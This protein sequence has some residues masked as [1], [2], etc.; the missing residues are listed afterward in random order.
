VKITNV[1]TQLLTAS[2]GLSAVGAT[3]DK[4]TTTLAIVETEAG[5]TGIGECYAGLF[6]PDTVTALVQQYASLLIGED[7]RRVAYLLDKMCAKSRFWAKAGL[8]MA[9][10]GTIENALW[11]LKG[12]ALGVPVYELLGGRA[13]DRIKVYASGGLLDDIDATVD[14]MKRYV[15]QGYKAVKIR[16]WNDYESDVR[17]L[18]AA[19]EALGDDVE[20]MVDAVMGHNRRP[21]SAKE[22]LRRTAVLEELNVR[23]YEEP[24]GNRDYAGYALVRAN[25]SV[26]VAGGESAVGVH[27]FTPFFDAGALDIAQPDP[28]H[29]G[30]I[31][32]VQHIA[33][34]AR[35][36]GVEVAYHSWGAAPC[37]LANYHVAFADP[38]CEYLEFPT[39]G[40]PF[41][42][43][44]A[45]QPFALDDD[46]CFAAPTTPGLGVQLPDGLAEQYPYQPGTGFWT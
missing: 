41:I 45:V 37:L 22:A 15:E 40:L 8:P 29:S 35:A 33:A 21:R 13:Q 23:W 1:R 2:A 12:Q 25:T 28:A 20:M 42:D 34:I 30:G 3:L 14:E 39:H 19:R 43:A 11:D 18:R 9:V 24:C 7:P 36:R 10:A 32:E 38:Y 17:K 4:W 16:I 6:A 44:L 27:E 5:L 31:I 46:G 26:P